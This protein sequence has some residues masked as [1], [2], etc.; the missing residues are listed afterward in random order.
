MPSWGNACSGSIQR[1]SKHLRHTRCSDLL[2]WQSMS[3]RLPFPKLRPACRAFTALRILQAGFKVR[4]LHRAATRSFSEPGDVAGGDP[5]LATSCQHLSCKIRPRLSK[6]PLR[7]AERNIDSS[8]ETAFPRIF[9]TP[10]PVNC[11]FGV[12]PLA[13]ILSRWNRLSPTR[14]WLAVAKWALL[15]WLYWLGASQQSGARDTSPRRPDGT[16]QIKP[17]KMWR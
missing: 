12:R 9:T 8:Q 1:R 5:K 6:P 16:P 10:E 4:A 14:S 2:R 17:R 11:A 13:E 7:G 3:T 15:R